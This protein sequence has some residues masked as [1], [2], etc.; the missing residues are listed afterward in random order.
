MP[1][2]GDRGQFCLKYIFF[3]DL[4]SDDDDDVYCNAVSAGRALLA[5]CKQE[6]ITAESGVIPPSLASQSSH[7][8]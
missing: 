6:G 2:L 3:C 8:F 5:S 1:G 4:G 7:S